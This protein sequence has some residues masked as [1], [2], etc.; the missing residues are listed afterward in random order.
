M[1]YI[2]ACL[3]Y[4]YLKTFF[5]NVQSSYNRLNVTVLQ[6]VSCTICILHSNNPKYFCG[7]VKSIT[8]FETFFVFA[9]SEI[10]NMIFFTNRF[11]LSFRKH[12]LIFFQYFFINKL[13]L[14]NRC[15]YLGNR[16]VESIII[17]INFL[18]NRTIVHSQFPFQLN[19][20]QNL[21][22]KSLCNLCF[23]VEYVVW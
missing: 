22:F 13:Q 21:V 18:I 23:L 17:F 12:A 16:S 4:S 6:Q 7:S 20:I 3:F 5:L 14:H 11:L 15:R 19:L 8:F 9:Y 2:R 1:N 10:T